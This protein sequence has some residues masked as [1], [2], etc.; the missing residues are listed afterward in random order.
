M[1]VAFSKWLSKYLIIVA[2]ILVI[3]IVGPVIFY[4]LSIHPSYAEQCNPQ[5]FITIFDVSN[6]G[7]TKRYVVCGASD[8][9]FV[10]K[11]STIKKSSW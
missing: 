4:T 9:D 10:I 11:E 8:K 5:R 2:V 7:K 6:D 3:I 1:F